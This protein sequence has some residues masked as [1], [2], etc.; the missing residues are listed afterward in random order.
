M[1]NLKELM[2]LLWAL[3][4]INPLTGLGQS[5]V[6]KIGAA[7]IVI[8]PELNSWV[9]GAG[10]PKK[11]TKV[12]DDLEA[13][14]LYLSKGG[15][16]VLLVSCD[17]VGMEP[18]LNIR[19]REAMGVATG[20]MPRDILISSTH[21]H[22][23]PSLV[24]TNYLM[25]LDT[26]YIESLIPRMVSMA[27]EAVKNAVP[28]KIGWAEGKAQIG[29][30][31]RLTWAD[32]THS[33][34]GDAGRADFAGLEG[35]DDPQHLALF[36]ADLKGNLLSILYHNTTHP[37]IFYADG[38]FSSD[39]PGEVRKTFRE[40]FTDNIPV[41]FLN[42]AQGDIS[43]ENM[44][45]K[46][47]ESDEEKMARITELVVRET[48]RLYKTITYETNPKLAH[49]YHDLKVKVRL[50]DTGTLIKSQEIL[51]RID[52]GEPIRGMEMIMAFGTVHLQRTFG[53]NPFDVLPVH[54]LKI[55]ELAVVTQPCELFSQFGLD[56]KRRSPG[57]STIVV[58]MTD[59][60]NG[61]CP[62]IYGLLGGGIP[63]PP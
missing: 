58:G 37:T 4:L 53:E 50:P 39:F 38:V 11:A 31:R 16:Q 45:D 34:H 43:M 32:G 29:Y 22:G 40:N 13:N 44:L 23:G 35:P 36:A 51:E 62:T 59:G 14:G 57:K 12:R 21:T 60:Y 26:A 56:I 46:K 15:F 48:M 28:G 55:G 25:P 19:L 42:G 1:L 47:A 3:F 52:E 33:M 41:L 49:E 63:A 20:I 7:S 18:A 17:L 54:A 61:Y 6:L 9:Q 30:N 2:P 24:K 27:K 5:E 8:S 10:V